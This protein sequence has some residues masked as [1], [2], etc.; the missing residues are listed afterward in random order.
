MENFLTVYRFDNP[1]LERRAHGPV[2][3]QKDNAITRAREL[4]VSF[5]QIDHGLLSD[6]LNAKAAEVEFDKTPEVLTV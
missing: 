6:V 4:H 2:V 1:L 5:T 3:S